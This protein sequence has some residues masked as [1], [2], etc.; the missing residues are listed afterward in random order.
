MV[1]A[2]GVEPASES[3]PSQDSTCIA[4]LE[5]SQA[6][7]KN[8][9]NRGPLAPID[10]AAARRNRSRQ[11][12]CFYDIPSPPGRHGRGGR[13]YLLS[14]E[15]ELRVGS[16]CCSI[17]FT[18]QWGSACIPRVLTPVEAVSPPRGTARSGGSSRAKASVHCT[19]PKE[20]R[21]NYSLCWSC[22]R[23]GTLDFAGPG[24]A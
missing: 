3:T 13:R 14:S 1:E 2:A 16:C 24:P 22:A 9:G 5:Y 18:S 19:T 10:L 23:L 4:V 20:R 12:A 6:T 8:S 11:P 17:G 15:S 7:S 21:S